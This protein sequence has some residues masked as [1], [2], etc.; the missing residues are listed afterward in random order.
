MTVITARYDQ[1]ATDVRNP[2]DDNAWRAA[3]AR[4]RPQQF[5]TARAERRAARRVLRA[6]LRNLA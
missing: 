2:P 4:H 5:A 1:L 3:R 6:W